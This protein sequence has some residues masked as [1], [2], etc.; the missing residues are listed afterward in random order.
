MAKDSS[1]PAPTSRRHHLSPAAVVSLQSYRAALARGADQRTAAEHAGLP[2]STLQ[3]LDRVPAGADQ[4][5]DAWLRTKTGWGFVRKVVDAVLFTFHLVGGVGLPRVQEFLEL[6]GLDA[7]VAS[8]HGALHARAAA[9]RD[10]VTTLGETERA[11]LGV[12]MLKPKDV[13]LGLDETFFPSG[14]CLVAADL[15]SGFLLV[16]SFAGARDRAAW[17]GAWTQGTHGLSLDVR[18]AVA[19]GARGIRAFVEDTL[20]STRAPDLFHVLNDVCKAF[21]V[22]LA[23]REHAAR[24]REGA[25]GGRPRPPRRPPRT[26]GKAR[27]RNAARSAGRLQVP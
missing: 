21:A 15:L 19:D 5:L 13:I 17:E 3:D 4:A 8:S 7:F 20:G 25:R 11:R 10:R 12:E 2:R 26:S 1:N 23:R 18:S 22:H 16:E 6:T 27:A 24:A 14:T 9:M